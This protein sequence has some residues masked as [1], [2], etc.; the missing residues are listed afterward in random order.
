MTGSTVT[1]SVD[2][3]ALPPAFMQGLEAIRR[4]LLPEAVV[5]V[6]DDNFAWIRLGETILDNGLF[7]ATRAR[8]WAR[9]PL[10]FPNA[11]PY[12]IATAPILVRVDGRAIDRQHVNHQMVQ[13]LGRVVGVTDLAF[14]SWDW[15]SMPTREAADL[16]AIVEWARRRLREG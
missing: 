14:Y 5:E 11:V 3:S 4:R 12:G 7:T 6:V 16:V 1:E 15:N 9:A 10:T 2:E 8:L 13:A